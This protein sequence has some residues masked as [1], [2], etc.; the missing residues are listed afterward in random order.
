MCSPTKDISRRD[1]DETITYARSWFIGCLSL[2]I[3]HCELCVRST[4]IA[5]I[6]Y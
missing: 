3:S 1:D 2:S 4:T 5:Q 6:F